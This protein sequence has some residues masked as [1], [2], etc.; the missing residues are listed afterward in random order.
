ML[1]SVLVI[2]D[3]YMQEL[4]IFCTKKGLMLQETVD[5]YFSIMKQCSEQGIVKGEIAQKIKFLMEE[6]SRIQNIIEDV[7]NKTRELSLNYLEESYS[8]EQYY[9]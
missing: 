6:A 8:Q 2:N 3:E 7:G 1:E 4:G 5:S 9:F